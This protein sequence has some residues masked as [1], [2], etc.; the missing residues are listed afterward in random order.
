MKPDPVIRSF[1]IVPGIGRARTLRP[2]LRAPAIPT[3]AGFSP[4]FSQRMTLA[5]G[6]GPEA[7]APGLAIWA[8][9]ESA[10]YIADQC[11]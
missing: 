10:T 5:A 7:D 1:S 4:H 3:S 2:R 6:S 9:T 11:A 8:L